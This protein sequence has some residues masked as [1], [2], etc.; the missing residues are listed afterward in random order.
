MI[1][2]DRSHDQSLIP[3]EK[4]ENFSNVFGLRGHREKRRDNRQDNQPRW[5]WVGSSRW[6][7]SNDLRFLDPRFCQVSMFEVKKLMPM[8]A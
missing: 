3:V 6:T 5:L 2:R 7:I 1:I 4:K 8:M